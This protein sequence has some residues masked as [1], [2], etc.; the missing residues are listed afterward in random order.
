MQSS[1]RIASRTAGEALPL[2]ALAHGPVRHAGARARRVGDQ[3]GSPPTLIPG[4]AGFRDQI[5]L[6]SRFECPGARAARRVHDERVYHAKGT[7]MAD[8]SALRTEGQDFGEPGGE[9]LRKLLDGRQPEAGY[10]SALAWLCAV[11]ST[12]A[13]SDAKTLAKVLEICMGPVA[14]ESLDAQNGAILVDTQGYFVRSQELP[15][16]ILVFRGTEFGGPSMT[17]VFTD[18]NCEPHQLP[19]GSEAQVHGG[20]FRGLACVWH[21]V[22]RILEAHQDVRHL[23]IAG[24]S[25]GGALAALAGAMLFGKLDEPLKGTKGSRVVARAL[26]PDARLTAL[27]AKLSPAFAGLYTYGQP[28]VG[29]P[30]FVKHLAA[31]LTKRTYRHVYRRDWVPTVPPKE[32]GAFEHF[33]TEF[34]SDDVAKPWALKKPTTQSGAFGFFQAPLGFVLQQFPLASRLKLRFSLGDHVPQRYI[35]VSRNGVGVAPLVFP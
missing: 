32:T 33:G 31:E 28:M 6:P 26:D 8:V 34:G 29:N 13:Y 27:R 15:V 4:R 17:D 16:G 10:D 18:L 23:F 3:D 25:L 11:A 24:H 9:W 20:F 2:H 5:P 14:V 35:D 21:D 19:A 22:L 1:A 12:W 30:A 7:A